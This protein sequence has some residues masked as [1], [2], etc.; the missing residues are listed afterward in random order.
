MTA[1]GE[2]TITGVEE[3]HYTVKLPFGIGQLAPS[4]ILH[5]HKATPHV[6]REGVMMADEQP[7]EGLLNERYRLLFGT[8]S[9][10]LF[11][12]RFML[13]CRLLSDMQDDALMI[14]EDPTKSYT[15]P[16]PSTPESTA[17]EPGYRSVVTCL[18]RV[19]RGESPMVEYE[20][21]CRKISSDKVHV[22]A[23]IPK[24]V[25]RC[26]DC[27]IQAAREDV[28]LQLYDYCQHAPLDPIAVRARCF[29]A[30]PDA[31][32]RMQ[33]DTVDQKLYFS[34]LPRNAELHLEPHEEEI[35]VSME[36]EEQEQ[37]SDTDSSRTSKRQRLD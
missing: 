22:M 17:E 18:T 2:G 34:Y 6:R 4:A 3:D 36:E 31:L 29:E 19:L 32:Y 5:A 8:E 7:E 20:S 25:E 15:V 14:P 16:G 23:A 10:Y 30:A 11:M 35:D 37:T 26:V 33:Y 12:R 13:L 27:L 21:M 9:V 1:Y 24:L 28:C